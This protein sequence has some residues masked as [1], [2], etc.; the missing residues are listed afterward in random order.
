MHI[1]QESRKSERKTIH[2]DIV[3]GKISSLVISF[4]NQK[5]TMMIN[6]PITPN[7][8]VIIAFNFTS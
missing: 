2:T 1:L 8:E 5:A 7:N 4:L 6:A 3:S